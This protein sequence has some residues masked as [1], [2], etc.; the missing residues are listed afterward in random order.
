MGN[1]LS[2]DGVAP[3]EPKIK[4]VTSAREP[5]NAGEVRSFLGLII[6]IADDLFLTL[7]LS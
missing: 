2:K 4:V 7:Q 5:K 1:L 3:E 6:I